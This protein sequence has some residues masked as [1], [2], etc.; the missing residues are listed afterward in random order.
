MKTYTLITGASTGIGYEMALQ[1]AAKKHNLILVARNAEKLSKLK[2]ELTVKHQIAV[3]VFAKDLSDVKQ[4]F[5]LYDEIGEKGLLVSGLI[6]NA[7]V[8][9]YGSFIET[10]LQDELKMIDLN[11]G[12]LVALTKLF[13]AEMAKRGEGRI[14]N[15]ASL[16]SFFPLPYYSVYSAT[17]AFVA[18]FTQT[19]AAE[20]EN[21]G[22]IVTALCPGPIDTPF[23]TAE[24]LKTNAYK[25]NKP[26]SAEKV[27]KA[28]VELFL[29]G[30]GK[31]IVGL[32]NWLI[33][34]LPLF[35]PGFILHKIKMN[36]TQPPVLK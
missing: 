14:M 20:L 17:K 24:M 13:G 16:L 27:A 11:V 31:K 3:E 36:L 34:H 30:R 21:N 29:N 32:Q 8:G 10:S 18:A 12:S 33:A 28:G 25:T 6:N 19:V 7:S 2:D 22:V 35:T 1:L 5:M 9:I 15:V 4:A 26:I 23:T